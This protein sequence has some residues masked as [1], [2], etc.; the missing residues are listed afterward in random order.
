MRALMS[1]GNPQAQSK[2]VGL[3]RYRT[4]LAE[5][6]GTYRQPDGSYRLDNKF[7]FMVARRQAPL[8]QVL[9]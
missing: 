5:A 1:A 8:A 9:R 6:I 4:A 3:D 2:I 7:V